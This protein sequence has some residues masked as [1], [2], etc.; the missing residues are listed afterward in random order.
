MSCA[1]SISK[2]LNKRCAGVT[3]KVPDVGCARVTTKILDKM[4]CKIYP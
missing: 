2:A 3:S 4:F 1:E